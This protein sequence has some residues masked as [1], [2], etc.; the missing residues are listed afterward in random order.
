MCARADVGGEESLCGLIEEIRGLIDGETLDTFNDMLL[1][2][3]YTDEN[4]E[5]DQFVFSL[6]QG[7]GEI[8]RVTDGFP[9]LLPPFLNGGI[10]VDER[11][12]VSQYTITLTDIDAYR[13]DVEPV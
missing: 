4:P 7:N 13:V 3:G 12:H 9:R 11:V 6:T 5:N 8:Y 1:Q 2:Y 10:D